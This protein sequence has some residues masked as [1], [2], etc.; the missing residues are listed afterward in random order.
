MLAL[1][2]GSRP[3]EAEDEAL[4]EL[5]P[6]ERT[7]ALLTKQ[8]LPPALTAEKLTARLPGCPVLPLSLRQGEV[9]GMEQ[10]TKAITDFVYGSADPTGEQTFLRDERE[11]DLLRRADAHLAQ[12]LGTIDSGLGLDFLSIDLRSAWE[13][14]GELTGESIGD[15]I[16]DKI[17]ST[18][19]IGK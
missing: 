12:A 9:Q 13:T 10:L 3:L 8:D 4:L 2:D 11:A 17:F 19:C 14:L 1:F 16:V 18:F 5:L 6:L 7:V 15:D